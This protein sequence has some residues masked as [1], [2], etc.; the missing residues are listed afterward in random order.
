MSPFSWIFCHKF[1]SCYNQSKRYRVVLFLTVV[2]YRTRSWRC[3]FNWR[4]SRCCWVKKQQRFRPSRAPTY[5]TQPLR[6][7]FVFTAIDFFWF[8]SV[9]YLFIFLWLLYFS[10]CHQDYSYDYCFFSR[11]FQRFLDHL[12]STFLSLYNFKIM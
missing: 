12:V 11:R 3:C 5:Q 4:T 6:S 8:S 9:K 1:R 10:D 2:S 7:K